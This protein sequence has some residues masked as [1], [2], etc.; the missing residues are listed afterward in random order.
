M[1]TIIS[2]GAKAA[3]SAQIKAICSI[4]TVKDYQSEPHHQHQNYAENWVGTLK[5]GTNRV[6]ERSGAH[7]SL[8]LLALV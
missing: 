1:E 7:A 4:Y 3:T 8:W 2:D 6:M 5:S